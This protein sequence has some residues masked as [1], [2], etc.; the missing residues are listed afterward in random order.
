MLNRK[1]KNEGEVLFLGWLDKM[2]G[3]NIQGIENDMKKLV[4]KVFMERWE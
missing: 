3:I 2:E 4:G 1:E